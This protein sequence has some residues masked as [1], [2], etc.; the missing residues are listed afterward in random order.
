MIT[1]PLGSPGDLA[2]VE[3]CQ[4]SSSSLNL[5]LFLSFLLPLSTPFFLLPH[6][7]FPPC[8]LSLSLSLSPSLHLFPP[9]GIRNTQMVRH[10]LYPYKREGSKSTRT[11]QSGRCCERIKNRMPEDHPGGSPNQ[12]RRKFIQGF[13]R[14]HQI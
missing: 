7:S 1:H 5:S 4:L 14:A 13:Q 10:S 2:V 6:V 11:L 3:L 9:L 12:A 8:S